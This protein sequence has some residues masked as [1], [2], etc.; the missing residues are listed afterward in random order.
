MVGDHCSK[1]T[2]PRQ[3]ADAGVTQAR[4]GCQVLGQRLEHAANL[5]EERVELGPSR[6]IFL[7]PHQS[8]QRQQIETGYCEET[9]EAPTRA[10]RFSPNHEAFGDRF[11][12]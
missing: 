4:I 6:H 12:E 2:I 11:G 3:T 5:C 1:L 9:R 10:H 8:L 7:P